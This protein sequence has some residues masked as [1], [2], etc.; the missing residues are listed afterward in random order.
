LYYRLNCQ[1]PK[2]FLDTPEVC[3]PHHKSDAT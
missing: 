3:S 1:M 2:P